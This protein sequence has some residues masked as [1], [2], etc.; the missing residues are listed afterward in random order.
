MTQANFFVG[1]AIEMNALEDYRNLLNTAYD[2][3]EKRGGSMDWSDVQLALAKAIDALGGEAS[4]FMETAEAGDIEEPQSAIFFMPGTDITNTV[5]SA[6]K[7]LWAYR[8]PDSVKWEDVDDAWQTLTAETA[9]T[10]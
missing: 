5:K 9:P 3:G 2:N 4:K 6:A 8:Y 10:P 7:L 1:P